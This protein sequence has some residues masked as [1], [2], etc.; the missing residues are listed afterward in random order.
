MTSSTPPSSSLKPLWLALGLAAVCVVLWW[1]AAILAPFILSLL[2][3]YGLEPIVERMVRWRMPRALAVS[4]CLIMV[5]LIVAVLFVLLVPIVSQLVPMLREQLPDLLV[6]IWSHI[7]PLL[8]QWGVKLPTTV[9]ALKVELIKLLKSHAS[10]WSGALWTSLL[11]GGSSLMTLGGLALLVPM[12]A[13]Y[14]LMD[15]SDFTQRFR[16][17]LP[18]RWRPLA[19]DVMA[20]S[21]ALM[22]QY[23]RGQV[24]VMLILAV[25]Y[26][27][28]LSLFGFA[29]AL[30]IGVLTGL[31]ICIPYLGFGLGLV[32]ASLAGLLQFAGTPDGLLHPVIAVA[33][34]YGLGQ[35]VESFFLTP[36][37]V[38]ER[39]GLHP[40]G[41]IFALMLFGKWMG[42]WG[43][44]IALPTSAFLTLLGRRL[45]AAYQRSRF[46]QSPE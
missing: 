20:E 31:A 12:L 36:R 18:M 37:L 44:L 25:Y 39:I 8:E 14:W 38:G 16:S 26:S 4:L 17:L 7:T 24:L 29:L 27:V 19:L 41:V 42:L 15:W 32:L 22:G 34:V 11:I 10:Q 2:L 43:V 6:A 3:A 35:V 13:F 33:V 30:P 45:V 9:D 28:G 46:Y 21:D 1:H 5:A 23:L 40:L